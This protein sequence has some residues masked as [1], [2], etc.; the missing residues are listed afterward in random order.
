MSAKSIE[1]LGGDLTPN[2]RLYFNIGLYETAVFAEQPVGNF[3]AANQ[4]M[5]DFLTTTDVPFD[6]SE[7]SQGHSWGLWQDSLP[8]ALRYL[9]TE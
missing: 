1:Q 7:W 8:E 9:F 2:Q 4:Q 3:L 5:R 6:Y